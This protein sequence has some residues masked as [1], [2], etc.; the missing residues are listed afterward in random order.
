MKDNIKTQENPQ[1]SKNKK[2]EKKP[3]GITFIRFTVC[4]ALFLPLIFI[5]LNKPQKF[6]EIKSFY[7][8]NFCQEK[9]TVP[10]IKENLKEKIQAVKNMINS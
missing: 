8:N 2:Q 3:I 10:E 4:S 1:I 6:E 7:Q 9:I 5:K